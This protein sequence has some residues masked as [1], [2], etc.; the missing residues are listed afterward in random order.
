MASRRIWQPDGA[1]W[2]A[3]IGVLTPD[4]DTV[5][6]SEF[7][8]M[9]PAGVSVSVAR[10]PLVDV[11]TYSAAIAVAGKTTPRR[12]SPRRSFSRARA[13]RLRTVPCGEWSRR[14]ASSIVRPSK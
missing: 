9:A 10:V 2:R 13:S 4:D 8:T 11:G 3:R 6:E 5:P 7:W 12:V 14:A 1:G